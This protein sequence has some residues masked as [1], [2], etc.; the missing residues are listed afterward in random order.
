[1]RCCA[2][3]P[4]GKR[5][6]R[7]PHASPSQAR[8]AGLHQR[9]GAHDDFSGGVEGSKLQLSAAGGRQSVRQPAARWAAQTSDSDDEFFDVG[10]DF[11]SPSVAGSENGAHEAIVPEKRFST[12]VVDY[13]IGQE[14]QCVIGGRWVDAGPTVNATADGF[15]ITKDVGWDEPDPR[16][17]EPLSAD[18]AADSQMLAERVGEELYRTLPADLQL[19]FVRDVYRNY[20]GCG[21]TK[22]E[23]TPNAVELV[24]N[25]AKW[26]AEIDAENL[27]KGPDLPREDEFRR[28][29]TH[30]FSGQDKWGHPRI[31]ATVTG[32][33]PIKQEIV[34]NFTQEEVVKMHTKRFLEFQDRKRQISQEQQRTVILCAHPQSLRALRSALLCCFRSLSF[35]HNA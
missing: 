3:R 29:A 5:E 13:G 21:W 28:Y 27:H 30:S 22:E 17:V 25:C 6:R 12:S 1:M 2:A 34:D 33:P 9:R 32:W 35:A 11:Q 10:E 24:R 23:A 8:A 14:G 18:E 20:E 31:W 15:R 4:A 16:E 26:R 19:A 7:I